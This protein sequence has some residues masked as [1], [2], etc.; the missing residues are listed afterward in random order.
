MYII[1]INSKDF[2]LTVSYIFYRS[3]QETLF[4]QMQ[5]ENKKINETFEDID[6]N[7]MVRDGNITF[8]I[9]EFLLID[10]KN[11]QKIYML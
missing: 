6:L 3:K 5:S 2:I 8:G 11:T 9:F 7:D 1:D 10:R 4:A